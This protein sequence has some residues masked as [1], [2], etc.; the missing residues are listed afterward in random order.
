MYRENIVWKL[1]VSKTDEL[2]TTYSERFLEDFDFNK[3]SL[4]QQKKIKK[5]VLNIPD[6]DDFEEEDFN[7]WYYYI[8]TIGI[9]DETNDDYNSLDEFK[10]NADFESYPLYFLRTIQRKDFNETAD[11]YT[12]QD[13]AGYEDSMVILASYRT[14]KEAERYCKKNNIS[15]NN[16]LPQN[17]GGTFLDITEI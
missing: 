6:F 7:E 15:V 11:Y 10:K 9:N 2:I 4:E 5:I 12:I 1:R 16:I 14:F 17:F 3:L 13:I 8:A